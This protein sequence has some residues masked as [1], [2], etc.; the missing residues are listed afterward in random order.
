MA[1]R[2]GE[3]SPFFA[4]LPHSTGQNLENTKNFDNSEGYEK[5]AIEK[6]LPHE[7][8]CREP[9]KIIGCVMSLRQLTPCEQEENN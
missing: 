8:A 4:S 7:Y 6:K 5:Q 2:A 9:K 1:G 3:I